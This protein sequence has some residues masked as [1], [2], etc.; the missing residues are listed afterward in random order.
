MV[1]ILQVFPI[2]IHNIQSLK[3]ELPQYLTK[4]ADVSEQFDP[5]EW[6]KLNADEL[7]NWSSAA[8]KLLV[9]QPSSSDSERVFSL[10]KA[11]FSKQQESSLQDWHLTT[12]LT[13]INLQYF[14]SCK[15]CI[16]REM[17]K[18]CLMSSTLFEMVHKAL[19]C[20]MYTL[21]ICMC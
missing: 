1:D 18:R 4:T 6:W 5:L 12:V 10:L 19:N 15:M 14:V 2:L 3:S 21:A 20:C 8:H 17:Y 11:S 16:V 9:L 7:P 13:M